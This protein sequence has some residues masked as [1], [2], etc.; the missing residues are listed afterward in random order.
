MNVLTDTFDKNATETATSFVSVAETLL[1]CSNTSVPSKAATR[2][3]YRAPY[4]AQDTHFLALQLLTGLLWG[5]VAVACMLIISRA[6]AS[7]WYR[8]MRLATNNSQG[9]KKERDHRHWLRPAFR[10]SGSLKRHLTLAPL[11]G[12]RRAQSSKLF[13]VF[14]T[15]LQT[16]FLAVYFIANVLWIILFEWSNPENFIWKQLRIRSGAMAAANMVP[17]IVLAAR[18]DVLIPLLGIRFDTCNLFH[19]WIGT[20]ILFLCCSSCSSTF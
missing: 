3:P 17:L 5:F 16:V 20:R 8:R 6:L 10:F 18:N 15:R 1:A 9:H 2:E 12:T 7:N 4:T 19:R 13:G 11:V 14:P